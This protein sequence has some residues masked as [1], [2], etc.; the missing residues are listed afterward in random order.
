MHHANYII[1]AFV[2]LISVGCSSLSE[3]KNI[4]NLDEGPIKVEVIEEEGNYILYRGGEPYY[5]KG[6]GLDGARESLVSHGANSFRTWG[7][8]GAQKVL[9]EALAHGMTVTMCIWIG[10]ERH[11]FDYDDSVQIELQYKEVESEVLKY[12]DHPALLMWAIGNEL[13]LEYTN[14]KVYDEVNR[15]SKMIHRVDPYHPTT[16]TTS[17]INVELADE[18]RKRAS[19]LDILSIQLYG[20]LVNLPKYMKEIQWGGPYMVTE[21]GAVG[22]WEVGKTTWGAPIEQ[23]SSQKADNYMKSYKVAIEP[24]LDQ[25]IGNYVFLWGQKQERTPT[26]YGM[27][28]SSGEETE[29]V[30][31]MHRIWNG[32]WPKNRTPR[33]DSINLEGKIASD[34][35]YLTAEKQYEAGASAFDY[36]GDTLIYNW[37]I[38]YE[39]TELKSGG[40]FEET[41][42]TLAGLIKDR[43]LS[44]ISFTAPTQAGA[45]RLFVYIYDQKG[46]AAH[47][48]IPFYVNE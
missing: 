13:N 11:G 32:E 29:P 31:V 9:D 20:D 10:H 43:G 25:C 2:F 39:S 40:D 28:L 26:W 7:T 45:Y 44:K 37:E 38:M 19:D 3:K 22:H 18:I 30:D 34:N 5:I 35:I 36:D 41:P 23:N 1:I 47:A 33:I 6:A 48:N 15:I 17:S 16:T 4:D 24:F 8:H 12:K 42:E 46:H 14:P 21:W 27:F